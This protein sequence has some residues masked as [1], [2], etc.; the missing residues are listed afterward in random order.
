[1][2]H[3]DAGPDNFIK[4]SATKPIVSTDESARES[5]LMDLSIKHSLLISILNESIRCPYI[6]LL[7]AMLMDTSNSFKIKKI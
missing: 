3:I 1:M 4:P 6:I 2:E 5:I 7:I